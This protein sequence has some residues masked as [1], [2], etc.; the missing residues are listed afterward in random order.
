MNQNEDFTGTP[1][2]RLLCRTYSPNAIKAEISPEPFKP[3]PL[4]ASIWGGGIWDRPT[5]TPIIYHYHKYGHYEYTD[6]QLT[7]ISTST[8]Y[9]D[10]LG[11]H[12]YVRDWQGNVRAVVSRDGGMIV[13]DQTTYYYPYG[14][15]MAESTSPQ[16]NPYK[17]TAKELLT[18]QSLNIFDYGARFYDPAAARWLS[19]D[20]LKILDYSVNSY[21]FCHMN[22][23]NRT[24]GSGLTDL[25]DETTLEH[26]Y[27]NDGR[28]QVLMV[29]NST[30]SILKAQDFDSKTTEFSNA[31]ETGVNR[32]DLYPTVE[33]VLE[34]QDLILYKNVGNC[35]TCATMQNN[36]ETTGPFNR[37]DT[38]NEA[39]NVYNTQ[40]GIIYHG[41]ITQR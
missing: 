36:R 37:I 18:D 32:T 33:N 26:V 34:G 5:F 11:T 25:L 31:L 20:P 14:L 28:N 6:E 41:R 15:P 17:Y 40:E 22:P 9:R 30:F 7:R 4:R 24:D 35:F 23:I 39:A 19:P 16:T 1:T 38:Y 13:F 12:V 3:T 2:G 21:S 8:G 27:V 29:S 10:S